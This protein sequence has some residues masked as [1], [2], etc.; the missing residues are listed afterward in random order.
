[1][2]LDILRTRTTPQGIFQRLKT[3]FTT[4][5]IAADIKNC[6]TKLDRQIEEFEVSFIVTRFARLRLLRLLIGPPACPAC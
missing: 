6:T 1:M 3:F 2:E 4:A 5:D